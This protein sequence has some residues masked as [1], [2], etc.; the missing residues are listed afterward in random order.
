MINIERRCGLNYC[1]LLCFK[2]DR[3][4]ECSEQF[5]KKEVESV[6]RSEE[7]STESKKEL[8]EMLKRDKEE[9]ENDE[10]EME[11]I[12][13]GEEGPDL[14]EDPETEHL[15]AQLSPEEKDRDTSGLRL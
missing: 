5:Y 14:G 9:R 15:L 13:R 2:S 8:I 7:V 3:H 4:Q 10:I 12:L 6:L 1:S 11:K